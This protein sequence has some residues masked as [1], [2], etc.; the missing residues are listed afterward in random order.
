L[1]I[2]TEN[3]QHVLDLATGVIRKQPQ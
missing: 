1:I 2:S 3:A